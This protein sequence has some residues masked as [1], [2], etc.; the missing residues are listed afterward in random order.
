[1]SHESGA[2][3]N[4]PVRQKSPWR[5]T[6]ALVAYL[7]LVIVPVAIAIWVYFLGRAGI[8]SDSLGRLFIRDDPFASL[9]QYLLALVVELA[10]ILGIMCWRKLKPTDLGLTSFRWHWV[11][12]VIGLYILQ[13]TLVIVAFAII[14]VISPS[15]N[16]DQKQEILSF[17][18][19]HWAVVA[20][21]V[22]AVAIAPVV[23]EIIF[24]GIIFKALQSSFPT[25]FAVI[26]SAAGFGWLHGQINVGIYTF[27]L[28]LLLTWLY[29]RSRSLYP[30]IILHVLNNAV[31]FWF[32]LQ[33]PS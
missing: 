25:W 19:A 5:A 2:K 22:A 6:D 8:I 16:L 17:G 27:L 30:G 18:Q 26:V 20:S 14:E 29:M 32:I 10:I 23:E 11:F 3:D 7:G 1:M 4:A 9:M 13:I 33:L 15:V 28:G 31:A 21:F 24:R 12:I